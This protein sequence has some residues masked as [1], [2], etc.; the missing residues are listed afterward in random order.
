M[1]AV[2]FSLPCSHVHL[3]AL[4]KDRTWVLQRLRDCAGLSR[5]QFDFVSVGA[6]DASRCDLEFLIECARVA[7]EAGVDR[8]RLADT[9][10]IWS[11]HQVGRAVAA[12]RSAVPDLMI[13]FHG[14]NDLGMATA[15]TLAAVCAGAASVDV[16]VNGL[17]E[18][19]GNAPLEE[20]V[21]ALALCHGLD[22]GIDTQRLREISRQVVQASGRP[23]APNKPIVGERLFC[24]ESGIH[25]AALSVE[26]KTYEP[27]DPAE[28]G[29]VRNDCDR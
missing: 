4:G 1:P 19:A 12:V 13:G 20:V 28:T 26:A 23:I 16:T 2:H 17:G 8:F 27:F 18:R 14:H 3:H 25:V 5:E 15:N 11:P 10:G 29:H 9:V 7:R 6:Q 22:C 24:H 21:M